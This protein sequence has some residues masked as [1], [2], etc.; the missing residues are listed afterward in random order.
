MSDRAKSQ[1]ALM[2]LVALAG[3]GV[4]GFLA[5][6]LNAGGV[7]PAVA[8][9]PAD[10]QTT[11]LEGVRNSAKPEALW[12]QRSED[13]MREMNQAISS[14]TK[15][16]EALRAQLEA[17][18]K[19]E[20]KIVEEV[21]ASVNAT[22]VKLAGEAETA[23]QRAEAAEAEVRRLAVLVERMEGRV[24]AIGDETDKLG[25]A[26]PEASPKP[27]PASFSAGQGTNEFVIANGDA[28]RRGT[29]GAGG[30]SAPAQTGPVAAPTP[31]SIEFSLEGDRDKRKRIDRYL[32]VGAYASAVVLSGVDASVGVQ[33]S[34][35]PRP[36]LLRVTGPA[37]TAAPSGGVAQSVDITGCVVT[38]EAVGDLSAERVYTRLISMTCA[39]EEGI[40]SE[41]EVSGFVAGQ[42]KAGVRGKV[43]SREGDLV[44]N[45]AIAGALG[46]LANVVSEIGST[47]TGDVTSDD[48]L[49]D[50]NTI[51]GR[52]ALD[53]AG[54]GAGAAFDRLATYY[55]NRAEQYQP[56]I[57][58]YGGTAVEIVF[59]K[60]V[61]I[62]G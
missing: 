41:M 24:E 48:A 6:A 56:V 38:A 22:I 12:V 60:G 7:G 53:A 55:I 32:P 50:L 29:S 17:N 19:S 5:F 43:V 1:K 11:V 34:S 45:A 44:Q 30:G 52:G 13:R 40:V 62:D 51:L 15:A 28:R 31:A 23:G 37:V 57:S 58:L 21:G 2:A 35:D 3:V 18:V 42:G 14:L 25:R 27:T 47:A 4:I 16:N 61:E 49:Q 26:R 59:L 10:I 33:S 20:E 9:G 54:Q 8:T 36:V 46:G 39:P